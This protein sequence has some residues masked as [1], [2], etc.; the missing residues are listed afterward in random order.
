MKEILGLLI[1]IGSIILG[2]Y[3]GVWICFVGGIIQ[4]IEGIKM[5]PTGSLDI[6]IGTLKCFSA[7]LVGWFSGILGFSI[8]LSLLKD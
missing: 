6:G 1:C 7:S 2:L 3:L 5:V 8:G 4:I